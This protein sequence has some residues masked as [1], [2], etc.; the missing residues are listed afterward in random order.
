[1]LAKWYFCCC[2]K[3]SPSATSAFLSIL[4]TLESSQSD[5]QTLYLAYAE[6][7]YADLWMQIYALPFVL[8]SLKNQQLPECRHASVVKPYLENLIESP[9]SHTGQAVGT[10]GY[11]SFAISHLL[12][13]I[14]LNEIVRALEETSRKYISRKAELE[15]SQIPYLDLKEF[16][17]ET[18][19]L[20]VAADLCEQDEDFAKSLAVKLDNSDI[21][22][23]IDDALNHQCGRLAFLVTMALTQFTRIQSQ[24]ELKDTFWEMAVAQDSLNFGLEPDLMECY[25]TLLFRWKRTQ[26][27]EAD[28]NKIIEESWTMAHLSKM[29]NSA[30]GSADPLYRIGFDNDPELRLTLPPIYWKCTLWHLAVQIDSYTTATLLADF[31]Q[32]PREV[33]K[34]IVVKGSFFKN[35]EWQVKLKS[36]ASLRRKTPKIIFSKNS[37]I[38]F[39]DKHQWIFESPWIEHNYALKKVKDSEQYKRYIGTI[40]KP[41][42]LI[43]LIAGIGVSSEILQRVD[44]SLSEYLTFC[45]F[46]GHAADVINKVYGKWLKEYDQGETKEDKYPATLKFSFTGLTLFAYQQL[47]NLGSG[48]LRS[49][50]PESFIKVLQNYDEQLFSEISEMHPQERDFFEEVFPEVSIRWISDAYPS[51]LKGYPSER[52]LSWIPYVYKCHKKRRNP[53]LSSK[54]EA[55]LILR[56]LSNERPIDLDYD[57]LDW[58]KRK[59]LHHRALLISRPDLT[60]EEWDINWDEK[61]TELDQSRQLSYRISRTLQRLQ[62]LGRYYSDPAEVPKDKQH[63]LEEWKEYIGAVSQARGLDRFTRLLLLEVIKNPLLQDSDDL[64]II[65]YVFLEY[66]CAYDLQSLIE[67]I[68]SIDASGQLQPATSAKRDLQRLFAQSMFDF[69]EKYMATLSE[70][71]SHRRI[72]SPREAKIALQKTE[73]F[74]S[75]LYRI[76]YAVYPSDSELL[77][78]F[79][80][81]FEGFIQDKCRSDSL[82]RIKFDVEP[83]K[84]GKEIIAQPSKA[85]V[86]SWSIRAAV[87]DVNKYSATLFYEDLDMEENVKN[88]FNLSELEIENLVAKEDVQSLTVLATIIDI[89][90]AHTPEKGRYHYVFNCGL[91]TYFE[92][93]SNSLLVPLS[94]Q[95]YPHLI[96]ELKRKNRSKE[97]QVSKAFTPEPKLRVGDVKQITCKIG[98]KVPDISRRNRPLRLTLMEENRW[99]H[100]CDQYDHSVW[101][102]NI[103]AL[104]KNSVPAPV[105]VF[106]KLNYREKWIPYD[107]D[108]FSL[109]FTIYSQH[110]S[111]PA[112]VLTFIGEEFSIFGSQQWRFSTDVGT[113]FI[114]DKQQF[115]QQAANEIEEQI[116]E[117]LEKWNSV[118]GLLIA[119]EPVVHDSQVRLRLLQSSSID[120]ESLASNFLD[121][122]IPFDYRNLEWANLFTELE[123]AEADKP[124]FIAEKPR[125][126]DSEWFYNLGKSIPGFPSEV[127]VVL[128]SQPNS[129]ARKVDFEVKRWYPNWAVVEGDPLEYYEVEVEDGN[130]EV[131]L[132]RWLNLKKY[133]SL[134]L[135]AGKSISYSS[136]SGYVICLTSEGIKVQVEIESLSMRPI[137]LDQRVMLPI[138][139]EAEVISTIDKDRLSTELKI[140]TIHI[141]LSQ[142][143]N[144]SGVVTRVPRSA[145]GE[146]YGIVWLTR[147]GA[148]HQDLVISNLPKSARISQGSLIKGVKTFN[149]WKFEIVPRSIK[150]RALWQVSDSVVS[151]ERLSYLGID[152]AGQPVAEKAPGQLVLLPKSPNVKEHLTEISNDNSINRPTLPSRM[153]NIT[154]NRSSWVDAEKGYN[155][156]RAVLQMKQGETEKILSGDCDA[157]IAN[158]QVLL[159]GVTIRL[160]K[161]SQNLYAIDRE[162]SIEKVQKQKSLKKISISVEE[163][164]L[165]TSLTD[166]QI[167]QQILEEYLSSPKDLEVRFVELNNEVEIAQWANR[168]LK[169]PIDFGQPAWTNRVPV[170]PSEGPYILEASYDSKR[171]LVRLTRNETGTIVASMRQVLPKSLEYF[172]NELGSSNAERIYLSSRG[173]KLYYVGPNEQKNSHLFE[174]GYGRIL[175]VP[176]ESLRYQG[177]EFK[178]ASL[179]LFYGDQIKAIEFQEISTQGN[180]EERDNSNELNSKYILDILEIDFKYNDGRTLYEER[181]KHSIV[182]MLYVHLSSDG[183]SIRAVHGFNAYKDNFRK[184]EPV[185][186]SL[187]P[188]DEA[189][190]TER[191]QMANAGSELDKETII[192]G[193]LDEEV[194]KN[195]SGSD[196]LFRH[197]RLSFAQKDGE[198]SALKPQELVF[199]QARNIIDL[200]ND[201][202]IVVRPLKNYNDADIGCDYP[203]NMKIIRRQFSAKEDVLDRIVAVDS[204]QFFQNKLLLVSFTQQKNNQDFTPSLISRRPGRKISVLRRIIDDQS[205]CLATVVDVKNKA[206]AG[207]LEVDLEV[208]IELQP[209][210]FFTLL[211]ESIELSRQTKLLPGDTIRLLKSVKNPDKFLIIRASFSDIRY[212]PANDVRPAVALPKQSMRESANYPG[213]RYRAFTIGS[214]QSIEASPGLFNP[215]KSKWNLLQD[216]QLQ[217]LEDFK[218]IMSCPHPKVAGLGKDSGGSVALSLFNGEFFVGEFDQKTN[219]FKVKD[220]QLGSFGKSI[221]PFAWNLMSF[222]DDSRDAITNVAKQGYWQYHDSYSFHWSDITDLAE[223]IPL[224]SQRSPLFFQYESGDLRLRYTLDAFLKFGF[225]VRE[226]ISVLRRSSDKSLTCTVVG[227]SKAKES[228]LWVELSPGRIVEVPAPLLVWENKGKE[229]PLLNFLWQAFAPGDKVTFQLIEKK[230]NDLLRPEKIGLL[231]WVPGIRKALGHKRCFLPVR[232]FRAEIGAL[233]L[234]SGIYNLTL[235]FDVPESA[236]GGIIVLSKEN[237]I[238]HFDSL[239]KSEKGLENGDVVFLRWDD[240][241]QSPVI[242]GFE[243]LALLPVQD[244]RFWKDTF[245]CHLIQKQEDTWFVNLFRLKKLLQ[246]L[247]TKGQNGCLPITVERI[248]SEAR[249]VHFSLRYQTE[250]GQFKSAGPITKQVSL[251]LASVIGLWPNSESCLLQ[252]GGRMMV[253]PLEQVIPGLPKSIAEKAIASISKTACSK[254][255]PILIGVK[256]TQKEITVG[257]SHEVGDELSVESV[258]TI[259]S[260]TSV[261]EDLG[262]GVVCRSVE[263]MRLYWLPEHKASL[264]NLSGKQL[265]TIFKPG[266]LFK[267]KLLRPE[268]N[269]YSHISVLDLQKVKAQFQYLK[270][271]QEFNISIV[272]ESNFGS[273]GN[274]RYLARLPTT[275]VI[276]E[277]LTYTQPL[278][279]S[280]ILAEV[281]HRVD[282]FR[283]LIT[284]VPLGMKRLAIDLP[285][286]WFKNVG[287]DEQHGIAVSHLMHWYNEGEPVELSLF[288]SHATTTIDR[289][290]YLAYYSA[291]MYPP[292]KRDRYFNFQKV[293]A[294]AWFAENIDLREMH[295]VPAVMAVLVLD[296]VSEVA[297]SRLLLQNIAIRSRRSLHIDVLFQRWFKETADPTTTKR[298]L[299]KR[300]DEITIAMVQQQNNNQKK[301][302]IEKIWRL[303]DAVKIRQ[304][305][306]IAGINL[307]PV[308]SGL[309]AALGN[310]SNIRELSQETEVIVDLLNICYCFPESQFSRRVSLHPS[311]VRRLSEMILNVMNQGID[312][313]LLDPISTQ[314]QT[315]THGGEASVNSCAEALEE[316]KNLLKLKDISV[317]LSQYQGQLSMHIDNVSCKLEYLSNFL[318]K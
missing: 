289:A 250:V 10:Y 235:P 208:D 52:W 297:L 217:A 247:G 258:A 85:E 312:L 83:C 259:I 55:G 291:Y 269:T 169:V 261:E 58:R 222:I 201:K 278:G 112:T 294:R 162:F 27:V 146:S 206:K 225:P 158:G 262:S 290:L 30:L 285:S 120:I 313:V 34:N 267:A 8:R 151:T 79:Q 87:F 97:W 168:K 179:I 272:K 231:D 57:N 20:A 67:Y 252:C 114:L 164:S 94:T 172:K 165:Q 56:F 286:I 73:L 75:T 145:D 37:K 194:Y 207:D 7:Q 182:H 288:E 270:T 41:G 239:P 128:A 304:K 11:S 176:S 251:S 216:S 98:G 277:C 99:T 139:R 33:P 23:L 28:V 90:D 110:S 257:F 317:R 147:D 192:Y 71:N 228:G 61:E 48:R 91:K 49:V 243:S 275:G 157:D 84:E 309:S 43:R 211:T 65:A 254:K 299:L 209:G 236:I 51:A 150:V 283:R 224:R 68:Y 53:S 298:G 133:S 77:R 260:D 136:N 190:L 301:E 264:A 46:I 266:T 125:G 93:F 66:G 82:R 156:F 138:V 276:L 155:C 15:P 63:W 45:K 152:Q 1:M 191:F 132:D 244:D 253:M 183:V 26:P 161:R 210:I 226:L 311:H 106:C 40:L 153:K 6:L 188:E 100:R 229:R 233:Y 122:N 89:S 123:S 314:V 92:Y 25:A 292:H 302:T 17:P 127:R 149:Q 36:L 263:T 203:K 21:R 81:I 171:A 308:A 80:Q 160:F 300:L 212:V 237:H 213:R 184:F 4:E 9:T 78:Q 5:S 195:S 256:L 115:T 234:G 3:A 249:I 118:H 2:I 296:H 134:R 116:E 255:A 180:K 108:L 174:W 140:D 88:L 193:R 59:N 189:R 221:E 13:G 273:K 214:L 44:S 31:W 42:N 113:N 76:V 219:R 240:A 144:C 218:S 137:S 268:N 173:K 135:R 117:A 101:E 187:D 242:V 142:T 246:L 295:L 14:G 205:S 199:L 170:A 306:P 103:S 121:L 129:D 271:G 107:R 143:K 95:F 74:R 148:V 102:A 47:S 274:Q 105:S 62:V 185:Q 293:A 54:Q 200:P 109:L 50:S 141:D 130:W 279:E 204:P 245:S 104:F 315:L 19:I 131:F 181:K 284:A 280:E 24:A 227:V 175:I 22:Y 197:V 303:Y 177:R 60:L 119:V 163:N 126:S 282:G 202:A 318:E 196:V 166:D 167:Q 307:L 186:A 111:R 223:E 159:D 29:P 39:S 72:Q 18:S 241:K 70:I 38:S 220:N 248:S 287:E 16:L 96:L 281:T 305:D 238:K 178:Q 35:E 12:E 230:E 316:D 69:V 265:N 32:V 198:A 232:S 124:F 64:K 86:D 154:R 215:Q 310:L